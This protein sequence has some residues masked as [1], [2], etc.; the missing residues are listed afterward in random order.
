MK[1][2]MALL[3]LALA[4]CASGDRSDDGD[5]RPVVYGGVSGGLSHVER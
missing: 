5:P 1:A 2:V 4:G 3:L